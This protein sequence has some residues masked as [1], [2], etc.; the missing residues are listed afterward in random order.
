MRNIGNS[1]DRTALQGRRR[2]SVFGRTVP[3]HFIIVSPG[4]M[5]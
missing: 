2:V 1:M 5:S 3:V 4:A